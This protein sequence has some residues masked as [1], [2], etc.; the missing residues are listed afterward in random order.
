[1]ASDGYEPEDDE[2]GAGDY[3]LDESDTDDESEWDED[4]ES[5]GSPD[6]SPSGHL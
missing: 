6:E 5:V 2:F 3:D 4:D 1:M